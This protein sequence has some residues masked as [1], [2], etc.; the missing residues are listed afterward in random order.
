M[1]DELLLRKVMTESE[2]TF[3]RKETVNIL[4]AITKRDSGIQRLYDNG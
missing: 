2:W 3:K 1:R 4:M